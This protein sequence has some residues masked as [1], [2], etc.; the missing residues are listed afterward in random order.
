[1]G[2]IDALA[3]HGFLQRAVMASVLASVVCGLVGPYV[4][5]RRITFLAGSIAHA[6]LAGVGVAAVTG[7]D[8]FGGALVAAVV[9][10]VLITVLHQK[11]LPWQDA[12]VGAIWAVGMAVG[13]LLLSRL[14][15]YQADLQSFLFGN[16]LLVSQGEL[17]WMA[18]LSAGVGFCFWMF[19]NQ[20]LA[21]GF[22]EEH[23]RLQGL[24]VVWLN[25]LMLSLVSVAVVVLMR[26]AGLVLVVALVSLP[27]AMA[28]QLT[29]RL[30]VAMVLAGVFCGLFTV[31]G[32][33]V[34]YGPDLP[35]GA[36]AVL[37]GAGVFLLQQGVLWAGRKV[38]DRCSA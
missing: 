18:L 35:P 23:A 1:M 15:G 6:V 16:L 14:P 32:L 37:L 33:G 4:V 25:G 12:I 2:F 38:R 11:K 28:L 3:E 36:T 22:D 17:R 29:R 31:G 21:L 34:A 30:G 20:F 19:K 13:V 24:P 27:A 26:V 5:V 7:Q 10:A 9:C 8:T